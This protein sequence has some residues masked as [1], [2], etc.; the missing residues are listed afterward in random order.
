MSGAAR[1]QHSAHQGYVLGIDLGGTHLKG[2]IVAPDGQLVFEVQT[3][4]E[5]HTQ[6]EQVVDR[7]AALIQRLQAEARSRAH[8]LVGAGLA[9]TLDVD[10]DRGRFLPVHYP[11]LTR[12]NDFP[13]ARHLS[14]QCGLAVC[15]EN[16]GIAAAWGEYRAG[17]GL[18]TK[19]MLLVC[20]GTGI[21]GGAILEGRRLSESLGSAAFFG[22]MV[23][24]FDGPP[25]PCG[26]R[27]CWEMYASA[28][29]LQQRAAH[30][31]AIQRGDTSLYPEPSGKDLVEAA[32]RGDSLAMSLFEE[33][34]GYLGIG[35]TNL[36]NLF[37]PEVIIIGGGLSLAG[38]LLLGPARRILNAQRLPL[39]GSPKL[40]PAR[41][42][43]N[44]GLI[45][46]ALLAWDV[47]KCVAPD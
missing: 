33:A 25:C 29:A 14:E 43:L 19:S 35:L 4:S 45:G 2:G 10:A 23:I 47:V 30:S 40:V 37:N 20:L 11:H 39:K 8:P 41:H 1:S 5:L 17:A 46:A 7:L 13:I 22:H 18:G 38:E 28:T 21:G 44:A 24:N 3:T 26:R 27:G 31:I 34:S 16:D 42:P 32:R 15:V 9:S 12:W 6:P 36:A